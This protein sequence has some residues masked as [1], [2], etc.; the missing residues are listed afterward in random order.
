MDVLTVSLLVLE[1][2]VLFLVIRTAGFLPF[3]T[4]LMLYIAFAQIVFVLYQYKL[5]HYDFL[6]TWTRGGVDSYPWK[7]LR[8]YQA[9]FFTVAV[10]CHGHAKSLRGLIGRLSRASDSLRMRLQRR[11]VVF[12]SLAV[13]AIHTLM[14]MIFVD[15]DKWWVN[16]NYLTPLTSQ[17]VDALA[18]VASLV[19]LASPFVSMVCSALIVVSLYY[20]LHVFALL[21]AIFALLHFVTYFGLH[22]RVSAITPA[23]IATLWWFLKLR[24]R[25][26]VL[27]AS[28]ACAVS[29]LAC[30]LVGRGMA[31]HGVS[32]IPATIE[33]TIDNGIEGN[34]SLVLTNFTEGIFVTAEGFTINH[35]YPLSY[36]ALSLSPLPSLIDGFASIRP[37]FAIRL[38]PYVPVGGITEA[39]NFGYIYIIFLVAIYYI[40]VRLNLYFVKRYPVF[41][42]VCNFLIFFSLYH[43]SDYALRNALKYLWMSDY[44]G[45]IVILGT[46]MR[47]PQVKSLARPGVRPMDASRR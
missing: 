15:F 42:L 5:V 38:S 40:S 22:S 1:L 3:P 12:I 44:L 24:G 19:F 41:F 8:L 31:V 34:T 4:G 30:A 21:F 45:A 18:P 2:P 37:R 36:K 35:L 47:K 20:R 26:V 28:F 39:L 46:L 9:I 7:T 6:Q 23:I 14:W 27:I 10:F 25:R 32:S 43:I 17:D 11:Q 33:A 16:F 13:V 29:C